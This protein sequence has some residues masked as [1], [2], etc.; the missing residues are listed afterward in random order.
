ML[1]NVF[2]LIYLM[3]FT[4]ILSYILFNIHILIL[5][6]FSYNYTVERQ[7]LLEWRYRKINIIISSVSAVLLR[8]REKLT[9]LARLHVDLERLTLGRTLGVGCESQTTLPRALDVPQVGVATEGLKQS[10]TCVHVSNF[11]HILVN[12]QL[13]THHQHF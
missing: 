2:T 6:F 7:E 3:Y 5:V 9:H 12:S 11:Y 8:T 4:L 10:Y 1:A 13:Q